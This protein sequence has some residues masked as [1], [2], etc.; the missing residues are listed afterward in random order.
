M[1]P[2]MLPSMGGWSVL[3]PDFPVLEACGADCCAK[4]PGIAKVRREAAAMA[5]SSNEWITAAETSES[6]TVLDW[7]TCANNNAGDTKTITRAIPN[8]VM[9]PSDKVFCWWFLLKYLSFP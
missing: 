6:L 2:T 8:R 3:S 1:Y 5:E 9:V 4:A 7:L